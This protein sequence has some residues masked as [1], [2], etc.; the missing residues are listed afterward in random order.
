M[1][2]ETVNAMEKSFRDGWANSPAV[3]Y[4]SKIKS[5]FQAREP[6]GDAGVVVKKITQMPDGSLISQRILVNE[7][8]NGWKIVKP[9][10]DL[11]DEED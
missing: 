1:L 11:P 5:Y 8:S 7:T 3:D 6:F 9:L 10:P 4:W 2:P